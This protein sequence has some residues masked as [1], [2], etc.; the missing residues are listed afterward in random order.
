MRMM[1]PTPAPRGAADEPLAVRV[2]GLHKRYGDVTALAATDLAVQPGEFFTLLGP[3]GS[4]KTTLL[5]LIAGFERP[6]VGAA[7]A[8][9]A[10]G[11]VREVTHGGDV[12]DL[13][14]VDGDGAG[15]QF[16]RL[17]RAGQ[18]VGA[19]AVDLDRADA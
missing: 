7:R 16:R 17:A 12:A 1:V 9:D 5:R 3:S 18:L 19:L 4:G 2:T 11:D 6:D 13:E 14:L 8:A 10:H 15:G